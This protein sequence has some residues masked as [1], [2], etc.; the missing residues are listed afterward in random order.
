M[1]VTNIWAVNHNP[2]EWEKPNEL[3]PEHHLDSQGKINPS[4]LTNIA[5]FSSGI[6]RCPA[7]KFAF[8]ELFLLLGTIIKTYDIKIV[9]P[10]EDMVPRQGVALKPKPYTIALSRS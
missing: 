1:V 7:D 5:T 9:K 4:A 10:P 3:Y 2:E 6:R 8:Y